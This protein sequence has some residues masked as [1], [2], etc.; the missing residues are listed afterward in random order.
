MQMQR[1]R[2]RN[3]LHHTKMDNLAFPWVLHIISILPT[4]LEM[5]SLLQ[6]H[7]LF[8]KNH[9]KLG[10]VHW[11]TLLV[12]MLQGEKSKLQVMN[13]NHQNYR[14]EAS[15]I[16]VMVLVVKERIAWLK[17]EC[18]HQDS[19]LLNW[20]T[21]YAHRV[22]IESDGQLQSNG[23]LLDSAWLIF[24]LKDVIDGLRSQGVYSIFPFIGSYLS[25]N[26]IRSKEKIC[27][28]LLEELWDSY[29]L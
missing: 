15:N 12:F 7:S 28:N 9:S 4:S 22:S 6:P 5:P 27:S 20:T 13:E 10:Q 23:S 17:L 14:Q 26:K 2:V 21:T 16:Q 25:P 24:A 19:D 11:V 29:T 18:R 3:S 8:W 1:A